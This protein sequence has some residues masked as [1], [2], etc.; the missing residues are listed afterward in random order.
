[1]SDMCM[2][3]TY[4]A[5]HSAMPAGRRT[6]PQPRRFVQRRA[7]L[8]RRSESRMPYVR[9]CWYMIAC[10]HEVPRVGLFARTV[11]NE[12]ILLY[13]ARDGRIVALRDRCCHRL[14]PLSKGRQEGDCV[15]CGYHGLL[16]D[17]S[18][19]CIE[20]P[21]SD[22]VPEKARVATYPVAVKNKWVFVWMG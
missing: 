20:I 2:T 1:M 4:D 3:C 22:S 8:P 16:F 7:R 10:D 14:A 9:N 12:G 21:G 15:R 17:A 13:R 11:L 18:G 5:H 19:R 6:G